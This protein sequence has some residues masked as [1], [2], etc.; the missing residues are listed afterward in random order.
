M[1]LA[2]KKR[3]SVPPAT[4]VYLKRSD[5]KDSRTGRVFYSVITREAG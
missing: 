5:G 2:I 4:M 3:P 1:K